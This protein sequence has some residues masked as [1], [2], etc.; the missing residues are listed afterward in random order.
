[1][2]RKIQIDVFYLIMKANCNDVYINGGIVVSYEHNVK[3]GSKATDKNLSRNPHLDIP[4][5]QQGGLL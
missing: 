2:G 5:P 4:S 1:M 3:K